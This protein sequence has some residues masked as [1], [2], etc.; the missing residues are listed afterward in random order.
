MRE[1]R[2]TRLTSQ[3][4]E[5]PIKV[6]LSRWQPRLRGFLFSAGDGKLYDVGSDVSV[7]TVV[8]QGIAAL[9]VSQGMYECNRRDRLSGT[10]FVLL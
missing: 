7:G 4:C 2:T 8:K 9:S 10:L 5:L 6:T 3:S 1:D